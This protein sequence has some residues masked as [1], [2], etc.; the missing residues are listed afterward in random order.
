V[1]EV[2]VVETGVLKVP[3]AVPN[4]G[5]AG[6]AANA[7]PASRTLT[8]DIRDTKRPKV[9]LRRCEQRGVF[10]DISRVA[11]FEVL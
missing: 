7:V 1:A 8:N 11:D 3:A 6:V 4:V 10:M 2:I 9:E 5:T